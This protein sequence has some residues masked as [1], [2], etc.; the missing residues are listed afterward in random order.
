VRKVV[1]SLILIVLGIKFGIDYLISEKFQAYA[2][3]TK[4]PWTCHV[5]LVIGKT[6]QLMDSP[7]RAMPYFN[8]IVDRCGGLDVASEAAFQNAYAVHRMDRPSQA[9]AAYEEFLVLHSTSPRAGDA[10]RAITRIKSASSF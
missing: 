3:R 5:T 6:F 1:L 8:R 2:D 9:V 10:Q 7:E 4:A